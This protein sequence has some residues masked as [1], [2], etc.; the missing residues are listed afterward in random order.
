MYASL[1]QGR[2]ARLARPGK[3]V[4][5]SDV[6]DSR[7]T[8]RP[9]PWVEIAR[10]AAARRGIRALRKQY[11]REFT[12][13]RRNPAAMA[14]QTGGVQLPV[15]SGLTTGTPRALRAARGRGDV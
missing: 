3:T 9:C 1:C 6:R 5:A 4:R 7:W 8:A 2:R 11:V 10:S 15:T 14:P 13:P 12:C